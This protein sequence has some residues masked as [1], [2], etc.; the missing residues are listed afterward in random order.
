[1]AEALRLSAKPLGITFCVFRQV[2]SFIEPQRPE[3]EITE[4]RSC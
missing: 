3:P 1:M 4:T 2:A